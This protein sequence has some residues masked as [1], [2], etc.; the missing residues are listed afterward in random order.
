MEIGSYGINLVEAY[1]HS[2]VQILITGQP[3]ELPWKLHQLVLYSMRYTS[4]VYS[5]NGKLG[6]PNRF[7]SAQ[8]KLDPNWDAEYIELESHQQKS[9][10]V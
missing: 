5:W 3:A 9:E 8:G 4:T 10:R 6:W 7:F 1:Q 2:P